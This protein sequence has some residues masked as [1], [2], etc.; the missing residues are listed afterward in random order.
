MTRVLAELRNGSNINETQLEATIQTQTKNLNLDCKI[1]EN[2]YDAWIMTLE[3][4]RQE[5]C[6]L[7]LFTNRQ[8]MIMVILLSTPT[9]NNQIK[10]CLL[11]KLC[12]SAD[13]NYSEANDM[14]L[15]TQGLVHYLRSV[16]LN[17]CDLSYENLCRLYASY[18][19]ESFD[20]D[21]KFLN[22]L[23]QFLRELFNDG[24]ELFQNGALSN[25]NEQYLVTLHTT[26]ETTNNALMA[27]N[28]DMK[29][30]CVLLQIFN[31]RLPCFFQILWC[32]VA[33]EEDIRLFFSRVRT[34]PQLIF[35]VMNIDNMH[36]RLRERLLSEQTLLIKQH[37]PHGP[38][39]YF[40]QEIMSCQKDLRSFPLTLK[41]Q[42][43]KVT[44]TLLTQLFQDSN[45]VR[46][47]IEIICG[48]AGVGKLF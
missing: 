26:L 37:Q 8:I 25:E 32:S 34:F 28:V 11:E 46:P 48:K 12:P 43:P 4:S 13:A 1:L 42:D 24:K 20:D 22:K 10:C 36:Y 35:V 30:C 15:T 7:Q 29:T 45:N 16:R 5:C 41:H 3:K 23:S 17:N 6:L 33:T 21:T 2:K 14:K 27:H 47:D 38:V 9:N 44:Y 39:Y 19:I 40:S 18:R 31:N